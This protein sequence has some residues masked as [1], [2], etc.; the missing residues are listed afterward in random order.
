ML[1]FSRFTLI[2]TLFSLISCNPKQGPDPRII[3][4]TGRD[5]MNVPLE[6]VL[7]ASEYLVLE[8]TPEAS[9]PEYAPIY[10]TGTGYYLVDQY[11]SKKVF[12]FDL[13]GK[14]IRSF[15]TPGKGPGEYGRIKDALIHEGRLEILTGT[16]KTEIFR[17]DREG[18]FTE[19]LKILPGSANS[20]ALEPKSGNYFIFCGLN[21]HLIHIIDGKTL[22][23][24]DSLLVRNQNLM[25][26]EMPAFGQGESGSVLFYPPYDNRIFSL[27]KD[28]IR[29][30][31]QVE[32]GQDMPAY[33]QMTQADQMKLFGGSVLW[34]VYKA[35]ENRDWLYLSITKQ[36][37]SPAG[38]SD[39]YSLV[40][41]KKSGKLY[42]LPENPEPGPLFLPAFALT[43]DNVLH[44]AVS[45]PYVF[46]SEIW[47][48][49]LASKG[50]EV[51]AE[52]NYILMSIPLDKIR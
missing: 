15:G 19:T 37:F 36:D 26:P 7:A 5:I 23:S 1:T 51:N 32:T 39:F 16:D 14:Y 34:L 33:D 45:Q 8:Y 52:G 35:M 27:E 42:R 20:F 50:I 17:Y 48:T 3:N 24:V 30:K 41:H 25:T 22:K 38:N 43:D 40:Y 31:Y 11:Q 13:K 12:E 29:V 2:L 6:N 18:R 28:T 46:D 9:L 21:K 10:Q 49:G 4:L 47:K 44:T